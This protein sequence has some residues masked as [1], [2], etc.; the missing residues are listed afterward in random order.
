MAAEGWGSAAGT[1]A[2]KAVVGS[3]VGSGVERES[4]EAKEAVERAEEEEKGVVGK[5]V[6]EG[7]AA[8]RD[9]T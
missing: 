9:S 7:K 8:A 2:A 1:A 4:G 6:V 3:V 5:G